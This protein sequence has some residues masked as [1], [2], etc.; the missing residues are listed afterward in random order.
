MSYWRKQLFSGLAFLTWKYWFW[1]FM[2]D[3]NSYNYS[4]TVM[5][6]GS[7]RRYPH[8]PAVSTVSC[9]EDVIFEIKFQTLWWLGSIGRTL[10][11]SC[12]SLIHWLND[13]DQ[14]QY[15]LLMSLK[16]NYV[17]VVQFIVN[18]LPMFIK[19]W[20]LMVKAKVKQLLLLLHYI[21][22]TVNSYETIMLPVS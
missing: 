7:S 18:H 21:P 13:F 1:F 8:S 12:L 6:A 17:K 22:L 3:A 9:T 2:L 10:F 5:T 15:Y 20:K 11:Y 14:I 16:E 19:S 4:T